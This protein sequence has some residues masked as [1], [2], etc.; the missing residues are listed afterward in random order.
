MSY[1][2]VFEEIKP[3]GFIREYSEF[4]L[5]HVPTSENWAEDLAVGALSGAVGPD[6]FVST[7]IGRLRPNV[8]H[9]F[10]GPSGLAYKTIPI[11]D[12]VIPTL[13][14]IKEETEQDFIFPGSFSM[15]GMVEYLKEHAYGVILRDEVSTLFKEP[16]AK[17]YN[18]DLLEFMSQLYDGTIQ[19]RF[20]RKAKLEEVVQCY[21]VFMG[22]TTPYL[23]S[24]LKPEVFVQGLGNRILFDFWHGKVQTFTGNE[25][26]CDKN[27]DLSREQKIKEFGEGLAKLTKM[28]TRFLIPYGEAAEGLAK[29][30]AEK[31]LEA[32]SLFKQDHND[33]KASYVSRC[34]EMA[35]KLAAL[36]AISRNWKNQKAHEMEENPIHL[37]DVKWAI[38]KV[39]RHLA[40]FER[41]LNEWVTK[42]IEAP[43][44][45]ERRS[46]E[47]FINAV[48][49][50]PDGI[51]TQEELLNVL[52][53][54]KCPKFYSLRETVLSNPKSGIQRLSK[55]EIEALPPDVRRRH[56][57]DVL[58]GIEPQVFAIAR[59]EK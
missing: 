22:A 55:E 18:Q 58:R 7:K 24:V 34:G 2:N 11:K 29:F 17:G 20:T 4:L 23:Y 45:S 15:E 50:S 48:K 9:I 49:S 10:V 53:W 35:I 14:A 42:P 32:N 13:N 57:L 30:K 28:K 31:D 51:M 3:Q 16:T 37:V 26:F 46:I 47:A 39:E 5:S 59:I 8:W 12:Y 38:A 6:R 27:S 25:L 44:V 43:P 33:L 56:G 54:Y 19:K 52:G 41:L 36:S 40:N 21:V 1:A